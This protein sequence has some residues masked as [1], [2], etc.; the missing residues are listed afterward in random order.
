[1]KIDFI[2]S[3]RA[4]KKNKN[5]QVYIKVIYIIYYIL[6]TPISQINI[7]SW[8]LKKKLDKGALSFDS[9]YLYNFSNNLEQSFFKL[10]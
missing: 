4:S 7:S 6:Y 5:I 3:N 10:P 9:I 2:I 1:M 8:Y